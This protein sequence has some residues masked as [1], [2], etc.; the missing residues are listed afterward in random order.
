MSS[1]RAGED[2]HLVAAAVHLHAHAVE[3]ALD[4]RRPDLRSAPPS[5][6]SP[7]AASIGWTGRPTSSGPRA[8]PRAP[9]ASAAAATAPRSPRSI[10]P[11]GPSARGTLGRLRDGLGHHALQRALA[12]LAEQQGDEEALL[13]L[14][15]AGEQRRPARRAAPPASPGPPC[16]PI[17]LERRVD[18]AQCQRRLA[19]PA[20][21]GRAASA[22]RRRSGAGAARRTGTRRRP[23][24]RRAPAPQRLGQRGRPSRCARRCAR[25]RRRSRRARPAAPGPSWQPPTGE[26]QRARI[27]FKPA[28][29]LQS[30][31]FKRP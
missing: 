24:P 14:G 1:R 6:S 20:R 19:S 10:T 11:G 5:M 4:R 28:G 2:A 29:F 17:A 27:C 9:P 25:R 7:G 13:V 8:A 23:P 15:R 22:S 18:L 31:R 21:A 26:R 16:A 12:Q 3:L 30:R